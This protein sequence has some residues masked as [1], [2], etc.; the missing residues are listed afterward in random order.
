MTTVA[1]L[2]N[3]AYGY[4]RGSQRRVKPIALMCVHITG[5]SKLPSAAGERSYA[6]RAGS[7]GP[8]AH[9]YIDRDGGV[10]HAINTSYAAWSNGDV[11]SPMADRPGV[12]AVLNFMKRGYNANEAYFR[13]VECVGYGT[14]NPVTD[15]QLR[16]VAELVAADA[17]V[18]GLPISRETVHTHAYLNSVNRP[19]C[20]FQPAVREQSLDRIVAMA[21][22]IAGGTSHGPSQEPDMAVIT[23][24]ELPFGGGT[25]TIPANTAASGI[26]L[27][28]KGA[29]A[30]RA[31]WPTRPTPSSA[32]YDATVDLSALGIRG[33][34]FI[35]VID[36]T[37]AGTYVS[38]VGLVLTPNAAPA[39]SDAAIQAAI[40]ADRAKARIV[41]G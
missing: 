21:Q 35:R 29:I 14:A 24:T 28:A 12:Q 2:T 23:V 33:N 13:E 17:A 27:D 20:A 18:T 9:D 22:L 5:N 25:F 30:S 8:S 32:H 10:V 6:N 16:A 4:P 7:N 40:A 38:T 15:A 19:S 11:Q 36:G 37:L 39:A 1:L 3:K 31:D 34:P 41:Y 26:K